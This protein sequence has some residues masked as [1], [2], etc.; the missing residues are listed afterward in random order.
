M[1]VSE[2]GGA[3]WSLPLTVAKVA[4]PADSESVWSRQVCYPSVCELS[5]GTLLVVW[6]RIESGV[7]HQSGA[8]DSAR[9]RLN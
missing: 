3:T 9:V 5:D 8:I 2:D 4:P 6:A 1:R 7:E